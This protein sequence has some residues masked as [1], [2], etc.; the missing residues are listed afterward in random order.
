MGEQQRDARRRDEM[1]ERISLRPLTPEEALEGLLA[2]PPPPKPEKEK[3]RATSRRGKKDQ[4]K[5]RS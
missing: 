2:T 4:A 5:D 3:A 1:A